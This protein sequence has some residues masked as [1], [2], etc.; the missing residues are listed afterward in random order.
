MSD[1]PPATG[2]NV[3]PRHPVGTLA[4]VGLYGVLFVAGWLAFYFLVFRARG[5]VTP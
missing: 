5:G 3:Q 1:S 4:I 2:H